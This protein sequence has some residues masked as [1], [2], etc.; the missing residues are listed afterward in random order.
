MTL[1]IPAMHEANTALLDILVDNSVII[2]SFQ[3]RT[4]TFL[5]K[6][7]CRIW[8]RWFISWITGQNVKNLQILLFFT[9]YIAGI[10]KVM[11]SFF[12]RFSEDYFMFANAWLFI[13]KYLCYR[14]GYES[15]LIFKRSGV[16]LPSR[17]GSWR[18]LEK[19]HLFV[20]TLMI[21]QKVVV[22][23]ASTGLS[24]WTNY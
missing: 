12:R 18:G 9:S 14:E 6:A 23:S 21:A 8:R 16:F 15:I 10:L 20:F 11:I 3:N 13:E 2:P 17:S 24:V 22:S 7:F 5:K 19:N 4:S 1:R